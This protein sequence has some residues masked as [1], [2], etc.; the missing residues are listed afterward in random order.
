MSILFVSSELRPVAWVD[1]GPD[2][3]GTELA[4]GCR[5]WRCPQS[6]LLVMRRNPLTRSAVI[7]K[8]RILILLNSAAGRRPFALALASLPWNRRCRSHNRPR[9][10]FLLVATAGSSAP[11]SPPG[12]TNLAP[13]HVP[14][15][16]PEH[17]RPQ[18]IGRN[19][20]IFQL[21]PEWPLAQLRWRA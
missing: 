4:T 13:G 14:F 20:Y 11:E 16:I 7:T 21:Q 12:Y 1:E 19:S 10:T 2:Q 5:I 17:K 15:D 6:V 18:S 9:A 8:M 3:S